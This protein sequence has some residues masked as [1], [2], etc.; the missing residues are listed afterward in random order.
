[1]R[2]PKIRNSTSQITVAISFPGFEMMTNNVNGR[3]DFLRGFS[4][5]G[6]CDTELRC[7][8]LATSA[9]RYLSEQ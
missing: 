7:T 5:E 3:E 6:V 1:M 2:L 9:F 4:K 8:L